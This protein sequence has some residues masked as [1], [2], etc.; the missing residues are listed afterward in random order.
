ML[1]V[2]QERLR[3]GDTHEEPCQTLELPR[4]IG[5]GTDGVIEE[6]AAVRSH[7][8][9][10]CTSCKH[11]DGGLGVIWEQHLR[12]SRAGDEHILA[13]IHVANVV[14][15][16]TSVHLVLGERS[17]GLVCL[18]LAHIAVGKLAIQLHHALHAERHGLR[19][20]VVSH[21]RGRDGV[22]TDLGGCLSLLVRARSNHTDGLTLKVWHIASVVEGD[23]S[24]LPVGIAGVLRQG[25]RVLVVLHHLADIR[26][27]GAEEVPWD[28]LALHHAHAL[29]L[30]CCGPAC[31]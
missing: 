15:A 10:A 5:I 23:V 9:N 18:V 20:L 27:L 14:G 13:H 25:L 19:G 2:I 17:A 1:V 4:S 3:V 21:C 16:H 22:E 11:D 8:G 6:E 30:G 24:R 28:L 7:G 12:T 29:L 31:H 26:C